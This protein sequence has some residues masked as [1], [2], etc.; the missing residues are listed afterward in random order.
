MP[1]TMDEKGDYVSPVDHG[2]GT[3]IDPDGEAGEYVDAE[4]GDKK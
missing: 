2:E 4:H 1:M 3:K